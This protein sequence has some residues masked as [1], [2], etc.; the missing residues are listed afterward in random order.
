MLGLG[1]NLA[2]GG[3]LSAGFQNTYSLAF[4]GS[5]DTVNLGSK[6]TLADDTAW[7]ISYW[8]YHDHASN[9]HYIM[10]THDASNNKIRHRSGYVRVYWDDG[11]S[12]DLNAEAREEWSHIAIVC[13]GTD[14]SNIKFYLKGCL[15]DT[16]T[17]SD[18]ELQI[19]AIGSTDGGSWLGNI[20]EVA[21]WDVALDADAVTAIYN[22]GTPIALDADSGNYDN[23]GD[24]QGWWRFEEGSGTS[25]ADS[26]TNS[27]AGTLT[28][29]PAY[30]TDV[31]S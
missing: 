31:P 5:N 15:E 20:D 29:G 7:T 3:V 14:S 28:N 23:S 8:Y 24:L 4:D 22:S 19:N 18:S 26:S 17:R 2:R 12:N 21:I 27:N 25:V 9:S 6:I 10:G 11:N 16:E 1:N 30:S 13:D